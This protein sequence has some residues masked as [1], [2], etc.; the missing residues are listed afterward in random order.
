MSSDI[1]CEVCGANGRR[2]MMTWC[3]EGWFYSEVRDDDTDEI[4][5]VVV[6]SE[7]CRNDFWKV[8]PGLMDPVEVM[9]AG[10]ISCQFCHANDNRTCNC[11]SP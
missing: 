3:P 4:L 6:C 2:R 9:N 1:T 7:R 5:M 8:G 11:E 10:L